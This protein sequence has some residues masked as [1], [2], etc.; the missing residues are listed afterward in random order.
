MIDDEETAPPP[1]HRE[2]R[3]REPAP[4]APRPDP[5]TAGLAPDEVP[6]RF[7]DL[8]RPIE[9]VRPVDSLAA[10]HWDERI[11]H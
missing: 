2:L 6:S 8:G 1:R 4:R 3:S 10:Q 9:A 5:R 11:W 7:D